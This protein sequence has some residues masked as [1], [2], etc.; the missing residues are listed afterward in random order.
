MKLGARMSLAFG[1]VVL[2]ILVLAAVMLVRL[3]EVDRNWQ[4]LEAVTLQKKT[5]VTDGYIAL[6]DAIHHFKNYILRGG[7]YNDKFNKD[8]DRLAKIEPAYK[9]TG[10]VSE[11][12]LREIEEIKQGIQ[13]Y[14][15]AMTELVKLKSGGMDMAGLDKAIAGADKALGAALGKL[16]KLTADEMSSESVAFAGVIQGARRILWLVSGLVVLVATV[17]AV[18]ITRGLLKQLG[19]EPDYAAGVAQKIAD[20]DLS[21]AIATKQGD[22]TSLLASMKV[23]QEALKRIVGDVQRIVE[24]ANKGDFSVKLDKESH[25]GFARD[26][27]SEL[28]Q[29][30]DT[31]ET[32]LKDVTRVAQALAA[33]DLS[34]TIS[35]DYPGLFGQTKA[36]VNGTVAALTQIVNE[37]QGIV[38]AANQGD[39]SKKMDLSGKAGYT[40]TLAE[41]LNQLSDTTE[42]GLKDVMRVAKALA[43]GD[44]SQKITKDYPGV[45]GQTKDAVNGTVDALTQI[46]AEIQQIVEAAAVRGDF[47]VKMNMA[48]KAG[49]TK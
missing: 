35:K 49:Y 13:K 18:L 29:L 25:K 44:L 48:G 7:D 26:I 14:R 38:E 16:G 8:L 32:G 27:A 21:M 46:V 40:Q 24:A 36:G 39:F 30:S 31:T 3:G 28:N 12:E 42:V 10:Q 45:F 6:G 9:Q 5:A 2:L 1:T 41:L 33:G 15:D 34:Q 11:E 37:I 4:N 17:L 19:G 20:G 47:S 23:M 43:A 22:T